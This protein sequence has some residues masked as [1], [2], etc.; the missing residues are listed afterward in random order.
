MSLP[1]PTPKYDPANEAQNRAILARQDAGN[2]KKGQNI[3][4]GSGCAVVLTDTVTGARY[5]MRIINGVVT[6]VA[7]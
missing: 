2:H 5:Y 4:V 6:M 1:S 3:E 7:A